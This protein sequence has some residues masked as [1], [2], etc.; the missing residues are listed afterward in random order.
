MEVLATTIRQEKEIKDI[1]IGKEEAKPSLFADDVTVY[2]ENPIDSTKKLLDIISEF[3]KTVEYKVN[4]QKSK[5]FFVHQ[6]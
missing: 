6:Q 2:I 1:Q 5:A 3:G 4:I